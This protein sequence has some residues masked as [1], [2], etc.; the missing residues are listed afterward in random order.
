[1]NAD[2]QAP[3]RIAVRGGCRRRCEAQE[4]DE[5]SAIA[6]HDMGSSWRAGPGCHG[7]RA[8][9]VA[10]RKESAEGCPLALLPFVK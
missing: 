9:S 3:A 2:G 6:C 1:M 10:A 5:P 7:Q 4:G 8:Q